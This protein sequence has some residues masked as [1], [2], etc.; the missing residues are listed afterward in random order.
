[1]RAIGF[2]GIGRMGLPMCANLVAAGYE[3]TAAD[4]RAEREAAA[5]RCGARWSQAP[6]GVAAGADLVITMLPGA[7]EVSDVMAGP[8]GVLAAMPA[9]AAWIDMSSNSPAAG[10]SLAAEARDRGIGVLDSPVGG[11]VPAARAGSL[12]LFV[13][14]DGTLLERCRPVL[15]TLAG[16]GRIAHVGGSGAGYTVKLLVNLL[17]FGQAVATAEALLVARRAGIDLDVL[18]RALQASAA[19]SAFINNDLD[20]LLGGDYLTSFELD[21]C[22][23]ELAAIV[24]LARELDVPCEFA[25]L[26][27]RTYEQALRRYGS[28]GGELL[29]VALLEEAAGLEL[30][31]GPR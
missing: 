21:R 13:G 2:I 9:T 27:E 18:R 28:V 15:E 12:Q 29:A 22:C 11:G 5:L 4:A 16:P 17:W 14:G 23:E 26:V 10:R 3:V 8:G 6:E 25:Q 7:R 24:G 20:A 1:V 31:H 30:R 19:S